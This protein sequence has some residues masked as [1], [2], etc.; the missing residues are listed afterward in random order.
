MSTSWA[1]LGK[2]RDLAIVY[3]IVH[4]AWHSTPYTMGIQYMFSKYVNRKSDAYDAINQICST[5]IS[6]V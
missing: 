3:Y 6:T 2:A 1:R 4:I 5:G